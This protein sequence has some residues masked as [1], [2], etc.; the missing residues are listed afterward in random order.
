[1]RIV[2]PPAAREWDAGLQKAKAAKARAERDETYYSNLIA[3]AIGVADESV[4]SDGSP[5]YSLKEESRGEYTVEAMTFRAL[6]R[7]R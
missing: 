6:R 7:M 4:F 3:T 5:A 2:L 1:M